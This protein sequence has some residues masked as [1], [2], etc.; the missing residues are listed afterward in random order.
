MSLATRCTACGT[1]FRVVQDQLKVSEG[2]V[3]CG[4]CGEVFNALEGLFDLEGTSGPT[5]LPVDDE[6][7]RAASRPP[8]SAPRESAPATVRVETSPMAH[9]SEPRTE[10]RTE[11]RAATPAD[12]RGTTTAILADA[13]IDTAVDS[14]VDT[15]AQTQADTQADTRSESSFGRPSRPNSRFEIEA[16][17]S[18]VA[19]DAISAVPSMLPEDAPTAGFLR[20]AARAAQWQR[21]RV[22]RAL[23]VALL[24][25]GAM[26]STQVALRERDHLAARWPAATPGLRALCDVFSC[27]VEPPRALEALLVESSGLTKVDGQ[28]LY[29]L[30]VAVRNRAA[31]AVSMP[32][33]DLTLTDTRGEIVARRVLRAA[34]LGAAPAAISAGA[35]W[36]ANAVLDVGEA[37]VSG[38]TIELFY[39]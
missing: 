11:P 9:R 10:P 38:Y 8:T 33:F 23:W 31:H 15:H 1:V 18:V 21:P 20:A 2:R 13:P 39:L 5:P 35:D 30:Q 16:V 26:L 34:E 37:R 22:R 14:G 25:L 19:D 17:D 7:P 28:P 24:L 4:R 3:R 12:A 32:A 36:S 27:T 6:P 29:R